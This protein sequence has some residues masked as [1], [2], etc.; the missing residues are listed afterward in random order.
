MKKIAWIGT[1]VM[2]NAIV[3]HL[4]NAGYSCALYNRSQEKMLNLKDKAELCL[5]DG[6]Y[7][8]SYLYLF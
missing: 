4:I 7:S 5:D 1:G 8:I 3:S 2:G 6:D